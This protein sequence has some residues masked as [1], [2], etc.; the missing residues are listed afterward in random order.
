VKLSATIGRAFALLAIVGLILAPLAQ[1]AMAMPFEMQGGIS[2]HA[3]ADAEMGMAMADNMP[4]CPDK[5][6]DCGKDCPL[7]ALCM[8]G[9]LQAAPHGPALFVPL[10]LASVILPSDDAGRSGLA[11]APPPRPPKA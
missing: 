8:V 5:T 1:P 11:Q 6:P 2:Q 10:T 7:M 4:C 9:V 3:A